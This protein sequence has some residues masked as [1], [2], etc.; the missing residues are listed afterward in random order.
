MILPI[1][2]YGAEVLRQKAAAA[3]LNDGRTAETDR[4]HERDLVSAEG[5]GLAA[6]Q[7]GKSIRVLIVD[8]TGMTDVYPYLEGF[9]RVMINPVVLEESRKKSEYRKAASAFPDLL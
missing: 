7:V 5:C 9:R 2:I 8:G 4:G 3:D 6:P 1:Y